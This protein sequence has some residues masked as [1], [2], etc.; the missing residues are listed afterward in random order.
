MLTMFDKL[1]GLC[2]NI[3][4]FPL[5]LR[6]LGARRLNAA[7]A[8]LNAGGGGRTVVYVDGFNLYYGAVKGTPFK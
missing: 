8:L 3:I 6:E 5:F 7:S 2:Y 1:A 4:T